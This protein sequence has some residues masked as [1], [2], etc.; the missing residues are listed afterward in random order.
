MIGRHH[1]QGAKGS[2]GSG[3]SRLNFC[4]VRSEG[5]SDPIF[6]PLLGAKP[7]RGATQ[8]VDRPTH[9]HTGL[10]VPPD[11]GDVH[12]LA[13]HIAIVAPRAVRQAGSSKARWSRAL[14]RTPLGFVCGPRKHGTLELAAID[15]RAGRQHGRADPGSRGRARQQLTRPAGRRWPHV[16]GCR[17]DGP[18]GA[19]AIASRPRT[20]GRTFGFYRLEILAAAVNAVALLGIGIVVFIEAIRRF[21]EP[22][23]VGGPLI[24]VVATI[25]LVA[26][27]ASLRLRGH[28]GDTSL[29]LRAASL[30]VL[31]DL[32]GAFAV[33]IAGLVIAVTGWRQADAVA[34]MV[35]AILIV[36]RTIGLLRDSVDVLLEAT[37]R[38]VDL[39]EVEAHIREA[40]GV[41]DVHDLHAWTITSGMNVVSAHV[42]LA[43]DGKPGDVLDHLGKCL[44]D[45]FDI[46]HSTFQLETPEHVLRESNASMPQH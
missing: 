40:P 35:I 45:D 21:G 13:H 46:D 11:R 16:R 39:G 6:G 12:V 32:L 23:D 24:L 37:P 43:P 27:T 22:P 34:S 10:N 9:G 33:L 20:T 29:N 42:V 14:N 36:P 41:R 26:N 7:C 5:D 25:A 31:G 30:E 18:L 3:S 2:H 28:G 8:A 19:I 15:S 4:A 17:G 44:S 38:G 1:E